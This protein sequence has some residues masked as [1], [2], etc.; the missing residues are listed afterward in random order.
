MT[1]EGTMKRWKEDG[2]TPETKIKTME[3]DVHCTPDSDNFESCDD[4][5]HYNGNLSD[6]INRMCIHALAL[7]D[8]YEKKKQKMDYSEDEKFNVL[9]RMKIETDEIMVGDRIYVGDYTAT[10]QKV[11]DDGYIFL[12]DQYIDKPMQMNKT[13]TNEGGYED[14]DLRKIFQSTYI[15]DFFVFGNFINEL[16]PLENGD[17]FRLPFYGEIFGHD[18]L[19]KSNIVEPDDCEQWELMKDKRNRIVESKYLNYEYGWLQNKNIM[20]STYFFAVASNGTANYYA[21]SFAIGIRPVFKVR[22]AN[23]RKL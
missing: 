23:W 10:C 5:I 21:A 1:T 19:Y 12:F 13:C 7:Y 18:N 4:C 16:A 6:C 17:L 11:E 20:S 8:C 2:L 9:R 14:S 3:F 22:K 15:L